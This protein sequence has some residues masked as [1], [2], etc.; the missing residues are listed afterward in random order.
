MLAQIKP[1]LLQ[2]DDGSIET[3]NIVG[4]KIS[5][6]QKGKGRSDE[7]IGNFVRELPDVSK[8]YETETDESQTDDVEVG[9]DGP[10]ELNQIS[11]VGQLILHAARPN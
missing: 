1:N 2:R 6:R 3:A 9:G 10:A 5:L 4:K 8:S 7:N 11:S